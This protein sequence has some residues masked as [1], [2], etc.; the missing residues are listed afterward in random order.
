MSLLKKLSLIIFSALVVYVIFLWLFAKENPTLIEKKSAQ[1]PSDLPGTPSVPKVPKSN[2]SPPK[3]AEINL[4]VPFISQ[5][6]TAK[7]RDPVFQ[8]ACEEASVL[9]AMNWVKNIS[10]TAQESEKAIQA[11]ADFETRVYGEHRDRSAKDTAQM[12]KDY[13]KYENIE[14]QENIS[15]EDIK[16]ELYA[17]HIVITPMNGQ[18]LQN[19]H[20][21][22]PGPLEHML[23]I[24]GYNQDKD[25]FIVN[26]PGTKFGAKYRYPAPVIEGA[27]RDYPTGY[28]EPILAIKKVMIVVKK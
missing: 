28:H 7:W 24:T 2:A 3:P 21:V 18:K 26:D 25:E 15:T 22:Q 14:Y 20:Y 5:A 17:G 27:L 13:F 23:V 4:E 11:L 9:M 12:I 6:P 19:P 1:T 10:L 16:N 8:N